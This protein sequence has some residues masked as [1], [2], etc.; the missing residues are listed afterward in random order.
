MGVEGPERRQERHVADCAQPHQQFERDLREER[1]LQRPST[2]VISRCLLLGVAFQRKIVDT[3][4]NDIY[5]DTGSQ[6]RMEI[7]S[8][9]MRSGVVKIP[10][11]SPV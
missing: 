7:F 6:S 10:I 1:P 5:A 4:T 3:M 9:E 11:Q 8:F 2:Q